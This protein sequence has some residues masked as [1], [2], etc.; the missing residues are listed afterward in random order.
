MKVLAADTVISLATG[1]RYLH[2]GID[3][4]AAQAPD[5]HEV[6]KQG[7][8]DGWTH[9]TVDGT[10]I[11]TDRCARLQCRGAVRPDPQYERRRVAV[12]AA[13]IEHPKRGPILFETGCAQNAKE[14]WRRRPTTR[15]H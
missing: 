4:L 1:D 15:S 3:V 8:A 10:L 13:V 6:L 5:L 11:R 7:K 2:E 12:I 14:E 9:V